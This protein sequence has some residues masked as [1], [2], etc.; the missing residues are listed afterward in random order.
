MACGGVIDGLLTPQENR[1]EREPNIQIHKTVGDLHIPTMIFHLSHDK[2]MV[3]SWCQMY[4][5]QLQA[6]L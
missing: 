2:R 6:S 5:V 3:V 1:T 4:L